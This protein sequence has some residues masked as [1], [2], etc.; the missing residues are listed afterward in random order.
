MIADANAR[1]S[2][3]F[4]CLSAVVVAIA[5]VAQVGPDVF[6]AFTLTVL[7]IV[8]F[9]AV[10]TMIRAAQINVEDD[11]YAWAI[12]RIRGYYA[13]VAGSRSDLLLLTQVPYATVRED[14]TLL[15][16]GPGHRSWENVVAT[17]G[18]L[19]VI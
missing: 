8:T 7:P 14:A 18:W 9:L 4:Y 3:L 16:I 12:A 5:F 11:V 15:T 13:E 6:F 2:Q 17:P 19:A 10:V 1:T